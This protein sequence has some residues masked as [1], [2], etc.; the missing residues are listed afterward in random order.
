MNVN[1]LASQKLAAFIV[2]DSGTFQADEATKRS[3]LKTTQKDC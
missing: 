3:L 2:T 1:A